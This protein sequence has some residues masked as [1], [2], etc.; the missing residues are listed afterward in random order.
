VKRFLSIA[1]LALGLTSIAAAQAA[2]QAAQELVHKTSDTVLERLRADHDE[3]MANSD[4][5]YP[6]VQ[7][8]VLPHFDF[9]KMSQW[10]LGKHWRAATAEQRKQ[11]TE[12]FRNL[13]VRTYAKA[14]LEY[15][16]QQLRYLPLQAGKDDRRVTVKT[17]IIQS[18][19][20]PIPINYAMY[21]RGDGEWKVYDIAVDGASMV[22]TY[23][24]SYYSQIRRKGL[25]ALIERLKQRNT[26][27]KEV[28]GGE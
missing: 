8:L 2:P 17:E 14:L 26:Q 7:D 6:L 16:D 4:R 5:I 20:P 27:S 24:K 3:L 15:D 28:N 21:L 1:M 10:V 18:G 22:S 11:F 25:D 19:G 12:Q 23:R 9:A 13:L